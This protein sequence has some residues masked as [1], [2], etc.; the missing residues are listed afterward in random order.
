LSYD[1]SMGPRDDAEAQ[2]PDLVVP[3]LR[4]QFPFRYRAVRRKGGN[5]LRNS[6]PK[7]GMVLKNLTPQGGKVLKG[8]QERVLCS[9]SRARRA[10][11]FLST[12]PDT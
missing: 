3:L 10:I 9:E 7:G 6:A 2:R 4:V 8:R 1:E 11:S 12:A 5:V